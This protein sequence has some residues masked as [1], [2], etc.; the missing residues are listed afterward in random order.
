MGHPTSVLGGSHLGQGNP[1]NY[2]ILI[3]IFIKYKCNGMRSEIVALLV[4]SEW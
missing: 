3:L 2:L 1:L 4:V